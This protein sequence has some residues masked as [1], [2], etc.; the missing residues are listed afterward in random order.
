MS[1]KAVTEN[2]QKNEFHRSDLEEKKGSLGMTD[3]VSLLIGDPKKAIRKLSAPIIIAMLIMAAYNLV[4]AVW[5]SG[6]GAN[7]LAAI[8]FVTP[9]YMVIFGISN[10]IGAGVASSISRKIGAK[11]KPGANSVATHAL[12]LV[13]LLSLILTI[14]LYVLAEPLVRA[15]GA[16]STSGLAVQYG[17]IIF[18]GSVFGIFQN[19]AYA[20]F[21]GEGDT[22]RTMY[23]MVAA[24]ILNAILDPVLIYYAGMGISGAAWGT[25]ISMALGSTVMMYWLLIKKDTYVSV[26]LR[27]FSIKADTMKDILQ[28]G[29]PASLEFLLL[30]VDA[31]ILN[32]MLAHVSGTDAVAVY[33]GGWRVIMFAIIPMV[34]ISTA[35][36]TVTGASFGARRYEN[37]RIIHNYSI[38]LGVIIGTAISIITWAMAPQIAIIFTYSS[39]SA[40]LAP[41]MIAFLST[42]CLFY[43]FVP[44]GI[45]S[46]SI[47]QGVG[48]GVTSLIINLLRV[49]AFIAVMAFVLGIVFELGEK[50]IWYGI[51]IGNIMGSSVGCIWARLY[52]KSL[53]KREGLWSG[54]L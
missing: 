22:K 36:L 50:G 52:I 27:S 44:A 17:R 41:T 25:V 19:I 28:V 47:F 18:L 3:G 42:M 13:V 10:G 23:V 53:A 39:N 5:V 14:P 43:P 33:T 9:I 54:Q 32:S 8:G 16:G 4:N 11:D 29:L 30:S 1:K 12:F 49:V 24:S 2:M 7:A 51:I 46:S 45:M 21:S 31:I 37:L 40:R 20:I 34:A 15:L 48:K 38:L 26:T 6:L 35:S